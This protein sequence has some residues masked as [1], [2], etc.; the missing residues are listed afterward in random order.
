MSN[1]IKLKQ[2][3]VNFKAQTPAFSPA[4]KFLSYLKNPKTL[5]SCQ[6]IRNEESSSEN[7]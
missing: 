3:S 2:N 1:T 7:I 4:F 5:L 6:L